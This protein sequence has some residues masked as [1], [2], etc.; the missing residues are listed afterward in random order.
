MKG[1]AVEKRNKCIAIV[2]ARD[3]RGGNVNKRNMNR[4]VRFADET[5]E[6]EGVRFA[7]YRKKPVVIEAAQITDSFE[8]E[9]LEGTHRGSPGDWLIRGIAGELYPCKP[10]IF[11]QTYDQMVG[12]SIANE[13]QRPFDMTFHSGD[14]EVGKFYF[15][16]ETDKLCF[17][18]DLDASGELF[19]E[20]VL[21]QFHE[22]Y[23]KHVEEEA[24]I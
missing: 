12:L 7:R 24:T 5:M 18:G 23:E 1:N 15:D 11:E 22:M 17:E 14:R 3:K 2:W 9:T 20:H 10:D 19:I 4:R 13:V 8:V 21:G 6:R 16:P